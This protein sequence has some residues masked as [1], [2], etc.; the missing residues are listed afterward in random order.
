MKWLSAVLILSLVCA[1]L[2]IPSAEADCFGR[3]RQV[4]TYQQNVVAYPVVKQQVYSAA[5]VDRVY[6]QPEYYYSVMDND[7]L[8]DAIVG[9]LI[10]TLNLQVNPAAIKAP[11]ETLPDPTPTAGASEF[12]SAALLKVVQDSCVRCHGPAKKDGGLS[13]V[14]PDGKALADLPEGKRWECF[15]KVT[16]GEMPKTGNKVADGDLKLFY[17]FAKSKE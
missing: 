3:S 4:I 14:T 6:V 5:V 15:G 17:E 13:L 11:P 10:R 12:Q 2:A 16:S 9:R 7:L 8:A 1:L